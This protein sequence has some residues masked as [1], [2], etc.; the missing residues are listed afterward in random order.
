MRLLHAGTKT[1]DKKVNQANLQTQ[2]QFTL[3]SDF[4]LFAPSSFKLIA[5]SELH[6]DPG[7]KMLLP[8]QGLSVLLYWLRRSQ[9]GKEN[10][11]SRSSVH[12]IIKRLD[13]SSDCLT[14]TTMLEGQLKEAA[15]EKQRGATDFSWN[16]GVF[17]FP[18]H[19]THHQQTGLTQL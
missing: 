15:Q 8:C 6:R 19:T 9:A 11:F 18:A 4:D 16:L 1:Q 12:S 5:R 10:P 17:H 2:Q 7:L 3:T 14:S 13:K